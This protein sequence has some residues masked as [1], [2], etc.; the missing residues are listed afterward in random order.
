MGEAFSGEV[1][2]L[3][4]TSHQDAARIRINFVIL[5]IVLIPNA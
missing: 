5:F 4:A 1:P 2:D 3:P